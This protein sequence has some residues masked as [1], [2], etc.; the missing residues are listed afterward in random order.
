MAKSWLAHHVFSSLLLLWS[1]AFTLSLDIRSLPEEATAPHVN[2]FPEVESAKEA[3]DR[4]QAIRDRIAATHAR[5]GNKLE[6]AK[7]K[8]RAQGCTE[9]HARDLQD[10][11]LTNEIL[12]E[13]LEHTEAVLAHAKGKHEAQVAALARLNNTIQKRLEATSDS[14]HRE[15]KQ[16]TILKKKTQADSEHEQTQA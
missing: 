1:L 16:N 7:M 5:N 2:L 9:E 6:E 13:K 3:M 15:V 12:G 4:A 8:C 11:E 10:A 14:V